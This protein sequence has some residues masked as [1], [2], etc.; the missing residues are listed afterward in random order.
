MKPALHAPLAQALVALLVSLTGSANALTVIDPTNLIQNT[1][2]AVRT[3]EMT[4][5]QLS[6]LQNETQMLLNQARNLATLDFNV[7][8]RLRLSIANSERLLAEA[9]GLAYEVTRLDQEFARLYPDQYATTTTGAQLAQQALERWN[10]ERNGLHTALR[11]QAQVA[12]NLGTDEAVLSDLV[13]QSQSA[14]GSLQASQATNQLLALQAKQ[15]IQAQQ[16]DL[17]QNRAVA[18]EHARQVAAEH[19]AREQR[20]RFMGNGIQYT[21]RPVRLFAR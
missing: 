17:S 1:L 18:L 6:Q 4:S 5:N 21:P 20:R 15:A 13:T 2:T 9:Q 16:L 19:E 7:I 12:R 10:H 3:L 11:I 8:N 14:V